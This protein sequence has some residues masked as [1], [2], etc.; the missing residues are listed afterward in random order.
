[1]RHADATEVQLYARQFNSLFELEIRDNGRGFN[2]QKTASQPGLGLRNIQQRA[3]L[4]GGTVR[5]ES[6]PGK[7]TLIVLSLPINR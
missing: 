7:G 1:V 6:E 5:I 3:R 2:L 4:H